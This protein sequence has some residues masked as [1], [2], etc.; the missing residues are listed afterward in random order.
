MFLL[1]IRENEIRYSKRKVL[2][3]FRQFTTVSSRDE[4]NCSNGESEC[5]PI[6]DKSTIEC[7]QIGALC[8]WLVYLR[9]R[10]SRVPSFVSEFN[11]NLE[12]EE[13][14]ALLCNNLYTS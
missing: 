10:S 6:V 1:F 9:S 13:D 2:S 4:S 12:K 8:I 7:P 11:Q 3:F 14:E 5:P